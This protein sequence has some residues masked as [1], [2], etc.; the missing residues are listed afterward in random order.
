MMSPLCILLW[1]ATE[2][3]LVIEP[4]MD[5]YRKCLRFGESYGEPQK[6]SVTKQAIESY[7]KCLRYA[8]SYGEP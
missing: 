3:A 8:A 6:F 1:R 2:R 7:R 5:S 4:A